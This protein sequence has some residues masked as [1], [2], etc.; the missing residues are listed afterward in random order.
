MSA[1]IDE[2]IKIDDD[3][4]ESMVNAFNGGVDANENQ[5][6]MAEVHF[7]AWMRMLDSRVSNVSMTDKKKDK[8]VW[9]S[10]MSPE[11]FCFL[12]IQLRCAKLEI[13]GK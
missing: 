6:K 5:Q 10:F 4:K 12:G 7:E 13:H 1:G 3:A 2:L 8:F 11:K 9:V